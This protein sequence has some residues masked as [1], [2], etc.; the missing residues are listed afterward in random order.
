M[1]PQDVQLTALRND[2]AGQP[3]LLNWDFESNNNPSDYLGLGQAVRDLLTSGAQVE[4]K[5]TKTLRPIRAGDIGLLCRRNEQVDLAVTS[6]TRWGIP[7][8]SPRPGLLGTAEAIFVMACLRRLHDASD[9]VASALVLTLADSTPVDTW[10]ADRLAFLDKEGAKS[11]EWKASGDS[12]HPLLARLEE[13]RP[14]LASLTPQESLRMAAAESQVAR[15][16]G[17]WSNSPHEARNRLANIEALVVMG[18]TYEDECVAAKRPATV[19]GMLRWLDAVAEAGDDSRAANADNS[20]AV[21][22][23]HRAKGL[24]WPVVVLTALGETAR[25]ALWSVRARTAGA[26]DPQQP[27]NNRFIHC[28]LKTWGKRSAPQAAAN[29]EASDIGKAMQADALAE[30]RRLL[31]VGLTRARDMN[32]LLSFVR[33]SGPGRGWVEEIP[34]AA[35]LLF[36]A[37]ETLVLPGG[38]Q[39]ARVTQPWPKD[40]CAAEPPAQAPLDRHWFVRRPRA[41]AQ[42]LWHRPSSTAGGQFSVAQ[43]EA[44]GVRIALAGKP[45][46]ANLG[47][48]LHLCIARAGVLGKVEA[49][50]VDRI[51][52]AWGVANSVDRAAAAAQLTAFHAWLGTRWRGCAVHVEVPIETDGPEGTRIRGRIDL[53]IDTPPGWVLLDHKSNPGGSDRDDDLAQEHGPQLASYASA[54]LAATGKPV[55]E[56][57][58]Y[59]PVAARAVR[60]S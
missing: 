60:L 21:L 26:F 24:E 53:L 49:N 15:L 20:V 2:I 58:L 40:D 47:T 19:S 11:H 36:G 31:Y 17:Q 54:L 32:V 41:V 1:S 34:G 16:V 45:D 35:Q 25:S 12:A 7:S 56:Q 39:V 27:L 59:L 55:V 8:A 46:M 29:A 37:T 52:E 18:N 51:L 3:S 10:L 42:P 6:L 13:L 28:W 9:T 5:G 30:S 57:W 43:T 50:E 23:Y 33:K 48:A 22:T 14:A 44:V 4:D 38:Q